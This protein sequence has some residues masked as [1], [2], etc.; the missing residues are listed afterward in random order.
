M[1]KII[2]L[3]AVVIVVTVAVNA[4][5]DEAYAING[6]STNSK[7]KLMER[8]Q[9]REERKEVKKINAKEVSTLSRQEFYNDFGDMPDAQW[10]RTNN[11]DEVTFTKDGA[12]IKA[13]YDDD[14]KLVGTTSDK[15]FIDL[16]V[17]GQ[18]NIN[19]E[20]KEYRVGDV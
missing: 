5:S 2:I 3:S 9:R 19:E 7:P 20:Y 6:I 15:S 4:Q 11:F 13:F 1:K 18:K 12:V 17:A 14:S 10:E 16:P 8:K